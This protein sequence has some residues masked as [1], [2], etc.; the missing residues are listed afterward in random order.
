MCL[1]IAHLGPIAVEENGSWLW[2]VAPLGATAWLY[3]RGMSRLPGTTAKGKRHV[4]A[5]CALA[6]L[7][8]IFAP[9]L[10]RATEM[11]FSA[12]M[13]QHLVLIAPIPVLLI[14][15]HVGRGL[16]MGLPDPLRRT[17]WRLRHRAGR[18]LDRLTTLPAIAVFF[19]LV[20]WGWHVPA[21]YDAAVA[22]EPIHLLEHASMLAASFLFWDAVMDARRGFLGRSILVFG[23][24]FQTGLLGAVLVFARSPLYESH[25]H[26]TFVSWS[27]L[28][29]QQLAGLIM[30]VPMGGVF[31]SAVAVIFF[32]RLNE[33]ESRLRV[34]V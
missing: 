12:H 27:P 31:L 6:L 24:A 26:Q 1:V 2:V 18:A 21:L 9:P 30:W 13:V 10:E 22:H 28:F 8:L 4:G 3:L 5:G 7:L 19:A 16:V 23:T 29:D 33:P 15:G 34:D 32:Q 11:L 25:L 17:S 20:I 14:Y